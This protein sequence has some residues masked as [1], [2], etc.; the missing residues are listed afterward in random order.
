MVRSGGGVDRR[1]SRARRVAAVVAVFAALTASAIAQDKPPAAPAASPTKPAPAAATP[2]PPQY[3]MPSAE[4]I[5][6]LIRTSVL[7][8][9][10]AVQTGNFTVL[11]DIAAPAFREQNSAARL[12]II[13]ADLGQRGINFAAVSTMTPQLSDATALDPAAGLLRLKGVFPGTPVQLAFDLQF[14][15]VNGT[16]RLIGIAVNPEPG[17]PVNTASAPAAPAPAVPVAS[18]ALPSAPAPAAAPKPAAK[19]PAPLTP[20]AAP[21]VLPK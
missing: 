12:G 20:A 15:A 2:A 18:P 13:F 6:V 5:L 19:K 10:D 9:N 8:L 1:G 14:Q 11:R 3:V 4:S 17:A 16:W 21:A 7:T